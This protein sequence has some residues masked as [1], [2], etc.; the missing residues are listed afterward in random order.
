MLPTPTPPGSPRRG[1]KSSLI[2]RS[3]LANPSLPVSPSR[4]GERIWFDP[5]VNRLLHDG[6]LRCRI[7]ADRH[8]YWLPVQLAGFAPNT[9]P[10]DPTYFNGELARLTIE[11]TA[12]RL[13]KSA[14]F[15]FQLVRYFDGKASNEAWHRHQRGELDVTEQQLEVVQRTVADSAGHPL[16]LEQSGTA[17]IVGVSVLAITSDHHAVFVRQA[18]GNAVAPD[19]FAV[20]GSGSLDWV[21][22][23]ARPEATLH[24]LLRAGMLR[25]LQEECGVRPEEVRLETFRLTG[26][27]RWLARAAKPE[28]TGFVRL[29][30]PLAELQSR[31]VAASEARF[32]R[33]LVGVPDCRFR[34]PVGASPNIDSARNYVVLRRALAAASGSAP[35]SV[36][37]STSAF[38]T[39]LFAIPEALASNPVH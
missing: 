34:S 5:N 1:V 4:P 18:S 24:D 26:Y 7:S 22:V 37:L 20:S 38:A 23:L 17:H 19:A 32:T 28:F 11:P 27:F 6:S 33:D 2:C 39:W 29:N 3:A 16:P 9:D 36:R 35:G 13:M 21:D 15:P 8:H 31:P 12:P 10:A 25:E 14:T 30:V